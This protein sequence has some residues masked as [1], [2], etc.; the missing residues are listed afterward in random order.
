MDGKIGYAA[1]TELKTLK[2]KAAENRGIKMVKGTFERRI[3]H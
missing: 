3:N 1:K 2:A